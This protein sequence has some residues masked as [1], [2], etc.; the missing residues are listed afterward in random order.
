MHPLSPCCGFKPPPHWST[1]SPSPEQPQNSSLLQQGNLSSRPLHRF[2][3]AVPRISPT[4]CSVL[5]ASVWVAAEESQGTVRP[6]ASSAMNKFKHHQLGA[7]LIEVLV[8]VLLLSFGLLSLGSMLAFGI[9]LPKLAAYR[10]TATALAA[11]HVDRI[12]ANPAGFAAS[13]YTAGLNETSDWSFTA[14][15]ISG[16]NCSFSGTQC[17][18]ATLASADTNE[19]RNAVRR[20]LPAGDILVQCSTGSCATTAAGPAFGELW[21]IWQEPSTLATVA[22]SS[23]NCPVAAT[24]L[25]TAPTPRCLYVRFK[26]E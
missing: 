5:F 9:Q 15:P 26:I 22:A 19:F 12:R 21:V 25:Y 4:L 1:R 13:S 20:D 6:H 17:T 7:S 16:T 14:I 3:L 23:D 11:S 24:T 18:T 10:A 8:A 2:S